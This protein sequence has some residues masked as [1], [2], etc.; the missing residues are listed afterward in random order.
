MIWK[1][2]GKCCQKFSSKECFLV[3]RG[4]YSKDILKRRW[5]LNSLEDNGGPG[6]LPG[7]FGW[8][9]KVGADYSYRIS[10][11]FLSPTSSNQV[12]KV[13]VIYI[14]VW[15]YNK[16]CCLKPISI[17]TIVDN[18]F[19]HWTCLVN[20]YISWSW[21]YGWIDT[22]EK[23]HYF[24]WRFRLC[25]FFPSHNSPTWSTDSLNCKGTPF[26]TT[27]SDSDGISPPHNSRHILSLKHLVCPSTPST[28]YLPLFHFPLLLFVYSSGLTLAEVS[29]YSFRTSC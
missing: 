7:C 22:I 14:V 10:S 11:T 5:I 26:S 28:F 23:I 19:K 20:A 17:G 13:L 12:R 3:D 9:G 27:L 16:M 4:G 2:I 29:S 15:I 1:S 21:F 18:K 6:L 24:G 8:H 25:K